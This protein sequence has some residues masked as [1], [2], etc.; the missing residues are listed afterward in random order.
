MLGREYADVDAQRQT[1]ER[2]RLRNSL[3][4]A[5]TTIAT[6]FND[7]GEISTAITRALADLGESCGADRAFFIQ[8]CEHDTVAELTHIWST[9]GSP[10]CPVGACV[11][12]RPPDTEWLNELPCGQA[13]S[14][15]ELLGC[16]GDTRLGWAAPVADGMS[17]LLAQPVYQADKLIG[18]LGVARQSTVPWDMDIPFL[19][20]MSAVL[21]SN[22]R[23]RARIEQALESLI[24]QWR[25]SFDAIQDAVALLDAGGHVQRCNRAMA[26]FLRRPFQQIIGQSAWPLLARVTKAQVENIFTRMVESRHSESHILAVK[27]HW[28]EL[29]LDPLFDAQQTLIGAVHLLTDITPR[30]QAEARVIAHQQQLRSLAHQLSVTELRERKHLA[31]ELH[32]TLGQSLALV[33]MNL[34]LIDAAETPS[35]VLE[36]LGRSRD[37]I[38][39][40]IQYTRSL[41]FELCPPFLYELGLPAALA[42]LAESYQRQ[43][44]I[45]ITVTGTCDRQILSDDLQ[46]LLFRT[47]RE[48]VMNSIKHARAER[49]HLHVTQAEGL[50]R[51][52]V[53]DDGMGFNPAYLESQ[54]VNEGHFGLFNLRER[55]MQLGGNLDILSTAGAGTTIK[56]SVP[57]DSMGGLV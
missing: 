10:S 23:E 9:T 3:E 47:A 21:V 29:R 34:D 5:L 17:S 18:F 26:D 35:T 53:I 22:A 42:W 7:I 30:K 54:A 48:L 49:I 4:C 41:T 46:G 11:P 6:H 57:E 37:L 12:V 19:L 20:R 56:V 39:H 14:R 40:A 25:T 43:Q 33:K 52:T 45:A 28:Y 13:L 32:E 2:L 8:W 27:H 50:V 38:A 51:L 55:V 16:P 1:V 36:K 44:E 15:E 31:E 24:H